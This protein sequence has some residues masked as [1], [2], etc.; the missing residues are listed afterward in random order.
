MK[1]GMETALSKSQ[2]AGVSKTKGVAGASKK[3]SR[4]KSGNSGV[5]KGKKKNVS[6]SDRSTGKGNR[7]VNLDLRNLLRSN[8]IG[9]AQ[10]NASQPAIPKSLLG[11]KRKVLN[12]MAQNSRSGDSRQVKADKALISKATKTFGKKLK[13]DGK[14]GWKLKGM[15][16]SLFHHQVS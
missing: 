5:T 2:K 4:H 16:T 10:A 14:G 11:D 9:D 1:V 3:T 12:E 8:V 15:K 7:P 6:K 13:A